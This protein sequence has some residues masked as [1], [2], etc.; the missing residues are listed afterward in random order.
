MARVTVIGL[1]TMGRGMAA[2]LLRA[3]HDVTVWNRSAGRAGDLLEHGALEA[4]S[5]ADAVSNAEFVLYCL[6]DDAAVRDVALGADGI[7]AVVPSTTVVVDLSTISPEAS[8]EAREAFEQRGVR[9][10]DAPVF[11]SKGEAAA[12][13]LWI[14]AGGDDE[15]MRLARP[16]LEAISSSVHHMGG[17]G[18]GVRMKL[19]G[20]LI[21]ASQLLALGESLSLAAKAGLDLDAVLGVLAVTDFRSPIFDGVGAAVRAG[22]YSPS[23]ALALMQ[24]DARLITA[25]ASELDAP[26]RGVSVAA[27]YIDDAMDAGYGEENAS[28]LIKAIAARAGVDLTR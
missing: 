11:G 5:I 21:V 19:V 1:G 16:V 17:S 3:D 6:S 10:L 7:A 2:N 12:G 22:D 8:A 4:A 28:A 18:T 24:K 23:F 15:T 9:F 26:I 20:N 25:F 27:G 13:G 14:V